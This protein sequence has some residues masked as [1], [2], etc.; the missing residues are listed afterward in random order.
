VS[1]SDSIGDEKMSASYVSVTEKRTSS[2][3]RFLVNYGLALFA[4]ICV[5]IFSIL[6]P[7]FMS[8]EN[9][10]NIILTA[11]VIGITAMGLCLIMSSG[12]IDFAVGMELTLAA[13][14]LGTVLDKQIVGNYFLG[15]V[16]ALIAM[17]AFG[18]V[19][20]FFHIV[21]GIPAFIATMGTS[22]IAT[23]FAYLATNGLW[24]NSQRWPKAFTLI[25]QGFV[26]QK[27]PIMV[28]VLIVVSIII[29]IYTELTNNGKKIYAVGS[30]PDACNY[31]GID[32]RKEKFK[33]FILCAVLCGIGGIML[34]SQM[35][36]VGT[37]MG[38][39]ALVNSL[40]AILLGA[41]FLRPGVFNI[42][43][44]ILGS[45]IISILTN[46]FVMI[47]APT[48]ARDMILAMVMIISVS[49][50]TLIRRRTEKLD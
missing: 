14:V 46:G 45:L 4:L 22:F 13:I 11:S 3:G 30:N 31:V 42:P 44:T 15:V 47:S 1:N 19:N 40:T 35:N 17:V 16:I 34:S 43:G 37:D 2:M 26:F 50:V 9:I 18:L 12:E 5:V 28:V 10:F 25:G 7:R 49:V 20:S 29:W 36:R 6:E 8:L 23:G 48:Y 41:T 32:A 38:G 24:I 21:V 33:G 27:V 39:N